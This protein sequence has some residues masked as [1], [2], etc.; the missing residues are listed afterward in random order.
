MILRCGTLN[1]HYSIATDD[2]YCDYHE[3]EFEYML[4][5]QLKTPNPMSQYDEY[6]KKKEKEKALINPRLQSY[7]RKI[8]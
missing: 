7:R 5:Q 3:R 2:Y 6:E 1:I 4:K 8:L